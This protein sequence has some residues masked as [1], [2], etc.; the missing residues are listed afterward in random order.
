M[1]IV[2]KRKACVEIS[3]VI[4]TTIILA[5]IKYCTMIQTP[6][7][8]VGGRH[9]VLINKNSRNFK[10]F[11]YVHLSRLLIDCFAAFLITAQV[12]FIAKC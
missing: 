9:F 5:V 4:Q 11:F 7:D 6:L 10:R 1:L 3:M 12:A 2:V 8:K